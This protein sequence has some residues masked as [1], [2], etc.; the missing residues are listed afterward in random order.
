MNN[1]KIIS[2]SV[3]VSVILIILILYHLPSIYFAE[4]PSGNWWTALSIIVAI[5]FGV[6]AISLT[7]LLKEKESTAKVESLENDIKKCLAD[8]KN[9]LSFISNILE[10]QNFSETKNREN[11]EKIEKNISETKNINILKSL[12]L[13]AWSTIAWKQGLLAVAIRLREKAYQL[14]SNN[15]RNRVMLCSILTQSKKPDI[16][17][18]ENILKNTDLESDDITD[19][20]KD[21]FYNIKGMFYKKIG[22]FKEASESFKKILEFNIQ[23]WP[24]DEYIITL[25]M[26]ED[27][28]NVFIKSEIERIKKIPNSKW[29]DD[30]VLYQKAFRLF[31]NGFINKSEIGKFYNY[32]TPL[33]TS[34][35]I[36]EFDNEYEKMEFFHF[37]SQI[38]KKYNDMDLNILYLTFY[39]LLGEYDD[40]ADIEI[41]KQEIIDEINKKIILSL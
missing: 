9:V 7:V 5:S 25:I 22:K 38:A 29:L 24:F 2:I 10:V 32:L 41:Q 13:R 35:L 6:I 15:F 36:N 3:I 18:I 12:P 27:I 20:D 19:D 14:D 23:T 16:T 11:W 28:G 30:K 39:K 17:K 34:K 33:I 1:F 40:Q 37:Y 26:R 8:Y 4:A 21:H 31:T